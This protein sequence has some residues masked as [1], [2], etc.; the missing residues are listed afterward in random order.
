MRKRDPKPI[1]MS[2][3]PEPR[4]Q[5]RPMPFYMPPWNIIRVNRL[6]RP[7]DQSLD[8]PLARLPSEPKGSGICNLELKMTIQT[9]NDLFL[10]TLKDIYFAEHEILKALPKMSAKATSAG[11]EAGL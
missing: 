9:M 6:G 5:S 11:I 10:H 3:E 2:Q 8:L 7:E 1:C 4:E